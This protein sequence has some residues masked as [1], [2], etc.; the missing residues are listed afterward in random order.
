MA[1]PEPSDPGLPI[2]LEP[3]SNG[4]VAPTPLSPTVRRVV[5]RTNEA[6]D[7]KAR[8]LGMTR[9]EFLRSSLGTATML[10]VLAACT[11]EDGATGGRYVER[12]DLEEATARTIAAFR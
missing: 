9:R 8:R 11:A 2:K 7:R 4:E 12:V 10:S 6:V 3:C 1:R 5:R